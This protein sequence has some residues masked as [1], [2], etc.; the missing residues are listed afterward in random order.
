MEATLAESD[1][2][3]EPDLGPPTAPGFQAEPDETFQVDGLP[4]GWVTKRRKTATSRS[5][6]WYVGPNGER[7]DAKWRA[8]EMVKAAEDMQHAADTAAQHNPNG[9]SSGHG[10]YL[11]PLI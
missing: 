8:W 9:E 4:A 3:V 2:D 1:A 10:T 6:I 7:A 11:P 5:Y